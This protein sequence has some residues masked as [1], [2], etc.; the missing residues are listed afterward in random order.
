MH[1]NVISSSQDYATVRSII[2]WFDPRM[3]NYSIDAEKEYGVDCNNITLERLWSH[4]D[5]FAFGHYWGWGMKALIIR[6]YGICW[7]IS[8]MWE[9]TEVLSLNAHVQSKPV[10]TIN[11]LKY[12]FSLILPDGLW[13]P[14][15]QLL[16]VLV[17]QPRPRRPPVQR[18]GDLHWDDGVP[19]LRDARAPL[20]VLQEHQHQDGQDQEGSAA[21]HPRYNMKQCYQRI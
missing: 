6:H 17:G 18:N 21:I 2:V 15:A 9:L 10:K 13:A 8:V 4:F 12:K 1:I 7:S 20:G 3:A 5:W 14:P 11:N 19:V 16:R